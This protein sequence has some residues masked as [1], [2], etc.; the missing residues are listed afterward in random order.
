MKGLKLLK[1]K[2]PTFLT[3]VFFNFQILSS[4]IAVG[5]AN[6]IQITVFSA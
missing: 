3:L 2:V 4:K 1:F 5:I 6:T